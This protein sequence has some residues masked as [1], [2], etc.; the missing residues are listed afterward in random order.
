MEKHQIFDQYGLFV[1]RNFLIRMQLQMANK[2]NY[3]HQI[4]AIRAKHTN[5][6]VYLL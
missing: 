4:D 6:I 5:A 3:V 1:S 2:T